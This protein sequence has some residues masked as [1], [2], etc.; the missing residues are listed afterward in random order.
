[1]S[2]MYNTDDDSYLVVWR[3][4]DNQ[5]FGGGMLADNE[6]EIFGEWLD[7]STGIG[8]S[9]N[10]F[11]ISD[12]GSSD[13]D[14]SFI[15]DRPDVVYNSS[16]DHAMVVWQGDDDDA[17][18]DNEFEIYGERLQQETCDTATTVDLT[19]TTTE[20][21]EP[22][23]AGSGSGNLT[24]V[25]TVTNNGPDTAC[26]VE[27]NNVITTPSGVTVDSITP[28]GST[29]YAANTWTILNMAS[30]NSE[31]L[32]IVL[33]VDISAS[34]GTNVISS[35]ASVTATNDTI[36]NP[37][38]DSDIEATSI[39]S[40]PDSFSISDVAADEGNNGSKTFAFTISRTTNYA[41]SS[42]QYQTA[43]DT[44]TA[45]E[46]YT[47]VSLT[48]VNFSAGGTLSKNVNITVSGDTTVELDETFFVNL[49]NPSGGVID[50]GQGE[51]TIKNDDSATLSI[52]DVTLTEGDFGMTSFD[53]AV[54][55]SGSVDS[56]VDV[57]FAAV[58]DTALVA[59]N[60]YTDDIGTVS[61]AGTTGEV[62]IISIDV[63]GDT[64]VEPDEQFFV[65]LSG[66][67]ANGRNVTLADNQ[68][69]GAIINDDGATVDFNVDMSAIDEGDGTATVEVTL[70]NSSN[71][72]VTVN[73][74]LSDGTATDGADYS[75]VPGSLTFAPGETSQSFPVP[76]LEDGIDEVDETIILTLSNATNAALGSSNN[77]STLVI[78]DDDGV[79]DVNFSSF[80]YTVDEAVVSATITVTLGNAS[81]Q[82]VMV[83]YASIDGSAKAG[84]DYT[85]VAGT[86]AIPAGTISTTFTVLIINDGIYE[87]TESLMLALSNPVNISIGLVQTATLSLLDNE[88]APEV[89]FDISDPSFDESVG[90]VVVTATLSTISGF[91]VMVD[92][93]SSDDLATA[94][95]DYTAVNST[96]TIP[97][98]QPFASF[99]LPIIDDALD[100]PDE[101]LL[102]TL[103][104][105]IGATLDLGRNESTVVI[106]DNDDPPTISFDAATFTVDESAGNAIVTVTLSGASGKEITVD[107]ASSDGSA[108]AGV[109][110]TAVAD[111]LIIPAGATNGT[112]TIPILD[113]KEWE[114]A[115]TI[116]LTLS[117]AVSATL[118]APATAVLTILISDNNIYL[119]IIMNNYALA[120]DLVVDSIS[121]TTNDV[122]IV[123]V[124]QGGTAVTESFWVDL[125]INPSPVPTAVNQ[126][127]EALSAQG[128][129]W[130]VE[131]LSDLVPGGSLTLT[132][133]HTAYVSSRSNFSGSFTPGMNIYV[134]VDSANAST[135]YGGVLENHEIIGATYNYI[136]SVTVALSSNN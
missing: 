70:S 39:E 132:L 20:S 49:A 22:V 104:N 134:Q 86:L 38:D 18:I 4:D 14:T 25:V 112:F 102:L 24:Y 120:P 118:T 133:N 95:E 123:I 54:T 72:T 30:G 108:L 45:G 53:F 121:V 19:V 5:D 116:N 12:M 17:L 92:Y 130:G 93:E 65:N 16:N 60:D 69:I 7:A 36:S 100:E 103:S 35:S 27:V 91:D 37:E 99:T 40:A 79:P 122:E 52:D 96:L 105:P 59:D 57:N 81:G 94:G 15:A 101:T 113:D 48:T 62:E 117:S 58:D 13:G 74:A 131:D 106:T 11:R 56:G 115:E 88:S 43:N 135:N 28:S 23:V 126:V 2:V 125:Y 41:D 68:A 124:N 73:Y 63:T 47:A 75:N 71:F 55:L 67:A 78:L 3:G 82:P 66:I 8:V 97:A 32:T 46:D 127:W 107:Y 26:A 29:G 80:N 34:A 6:H 33:T 84:F 98:G 136:N 83:D 50:D 119:P 89:G 76:I 111:T 1:P 51:G 42:V 61:F 114:Y 44:A 87:A 77:P 110:Y 31:T 90:T 64:T 10:D 9:D 109:D 128:I 21:I 85:A 129:A